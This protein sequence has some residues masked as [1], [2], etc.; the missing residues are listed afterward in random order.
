MLPP[1]VADA[2]TAAGHDAITP[3]ERGAQ[4]LPDDALVE[5]ATTER[6]VIVTENASDFAQ[7]RA[8]P[9]LF[10]LKVWWPAEVLA[11]RLTEALVRW[12]ARNPHP[13]TWPHWLPA[14]LR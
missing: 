8:C 13:G 12:A 7:V 9:V 2:L 3:A 5:I 4:N 6:R 10:V 14:E 11:P 1:H